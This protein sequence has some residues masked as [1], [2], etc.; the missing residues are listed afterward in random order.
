M[1]SRTCSNSRR[2]HKQACIFIS[3]QFHIRKTLSAQRFTLSANERNQDSASKSCTSNIPPGKTQYRLIEDVEDL[4][5]YCPGGYHPVRIGDKLHDGRYEIV[6]KLGYGGYSTIWL[7]RDLQGFKYVAVKVITAD[8]SNSMNGPSLTSLLGSALS[9]PGR[10]TIR[11]LIDEF[12]ASGPNGKHRCIVTRPAQM[13]LFEAKEASIF[14][15]FRPNI[16]QSIIAQ[17]IRGVA[18]L[19]GENIVHGGT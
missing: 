18:F 13:S 14:G 11:P 1:F 8:S 19:H 10:D 7:A 2:F 3:N 5:R 9:K 16:A 6:D 17:L 15:L 12:W 4:D